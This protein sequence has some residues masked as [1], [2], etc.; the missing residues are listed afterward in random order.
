MLAVDLRQSL[1][2]TK[3][4]SVANRDRLSLGVID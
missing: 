2:V 3:A 1:C 4:A